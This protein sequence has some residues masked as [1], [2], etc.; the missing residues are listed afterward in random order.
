MAASASRSVRLRSSVWQTVRLAT[1]P[2]TVSPR[3]APTGRLRPARGQMK[4]SRAPAS[5]LLLFISIV[6]L[7][8]VASAFWEVTFSGQQVAPPTQSPGLGDASGGLDYDRFYLTG[9]VKNLL[10]PP[11]AVEM[12]AGMGGQ[13]GRLYYS[14]PD[15]RSFGSSYYGFDAIVPVTDAMTDSLMNG[16]F[17]LVVR[18]Q[19]FPDGE[20]RGQIEYHDDPTI[21]TTW[22][23]VRRAFR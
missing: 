7:P 3:G 22:G 5:L 21:H 2:G 23:R 17:Y 16:C 13:N 1:G 8:M 10:S 15:L 4:F 20:I 12:H 18:T 11:I 9:D 19:A 6:T 14:I